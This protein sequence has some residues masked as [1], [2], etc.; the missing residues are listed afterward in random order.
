MDD[1]GNV[2]KYDA[3]HKV[4][5]MRVG[6][7]K[8]HSVYNMS[9][10]CVGYSTVDGKIYDNHDH[11][12]GRMDSHG[13]MYGGHNMDPMTVKA[14][15]TLTEGMVRHLTS[16][17]A[18]LKIAHM[19]RED[20]QEM[21]DAQKVLQ[22]RRERLSAYLQEKGQEFTKDH[23]ELEFGRR[24]ELQRLHNEAMDRRQ[25][26]LLATQY[27][28]Q[29]KLA[30]QNAKY[31]RELEHLRHEH[32]LVEQ[33]RRFSFEEF[34]FEKRKQWELE[35]KHFERESMILSAQLTYEYA[36][37]NFDYQ[38]FTDGHPLNSAARITIEQFYARFQDDS[39]TVPPLVVISPPA[40]EFDQQASLSD[41]F[42]RIETLLTDTLRSFLADMETPDR[43]INFQGGAYQTKRARW[44]TGTK[45]FHLTHQYA[46]TILIESQVS[47]PDILLFVAWWDIFD[48]E[49]T[50]QKFM[51]V[52][53]KA[54]LHD[55][56]RRKAREWR[57]DREYWAQQ[58]KSPDEI[59]ALGGD[60]EFNLVLLQDEESERRRGRTPRPKGYKVNGEDYTQRTGV[61]LFP[62]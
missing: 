31:M 11:Y 13:H 6:Y 5:G 16:N 48:E 23:S 30:K 61:G 12:V 39:R 51:T 56:A 57:E 55:M 26:I 52:N 27:K 2:Y 54:L 43:P 9:H 29:Q 10:R 22:T 14:G 47:G 50:Y 4:G 18:Q 58:G 19:R 35:L 38:R 32:R 25:K 49:P 20:N 1:Y 59:K 15:I 45:A 8:G 40:L 53:W 34:M 28:N 44:E 21:I 41:G 62:G 17:L 36:R 37:Q 24:H 60:D 33:E 3:D 46:P 7:I 42:K